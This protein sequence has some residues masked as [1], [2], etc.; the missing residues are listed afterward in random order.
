MLVEPTLPAV[1]PPA[2]GAGII[3]AHA[4]LPGL[5]GKAQRQPPLPHGD[6]MTISLPLLL[7]LYSLCSSVKNRIFNGVSRLATGRAVAVDWRD[8]RV[9]HPESMTIGDRFSSG[10]GLWLESV[11]GQ[12]RLTIGSGV[13]LSDYVHIGCASSITIGDGVLIGSKVLIT[14]HSHGAIDQDGPQERDVPP[15]LRRIASRGPVSIGD[16]AW[17]GDGVC[18]LQSVTVGAGAIVG[19]NSVVVRDIPQH[20]IWAGVPARQIW[21]ATGRTSD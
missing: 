20:T 21:P 10:K 6:A 18:I 8:I 16:N 1:Y 15:N 4:G 12:G 3:R 19:A 7:R 13:N 11:G 17:I 2:T 14:D 5:P 9:V